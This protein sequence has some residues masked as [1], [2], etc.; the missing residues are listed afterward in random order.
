MAI[1]E[2]LNTPWNGHT[3]LEVEAF[4]KSYLEQL[5]SKIGYTYV[6][7]TN[8]DNYL[9]CFADE[10]SFKLW[11]SDPDANANLLIGGK[12]KLPSG[13]GASSAYSAKLEMIEPSNYQVA[14]NTGKVKVKVKYYIDDDS[15][16][17]AGALISILKSTDNGITFTTVG[18][19]SIGYNTEEFIDISSYLD[20]GTTYI[21]LN[22]KGLI[23]GATAAA[24]YSVLYAV[25]DQYCLASIN[26]TIY[27][28]DPFNTSF[29]VEGTSE[30]VLHY[31]V[32]NFVGSKNMGTS[33]NT[34]GEPIQI[35]AAAA[36]LTHGVHTIESWLTFGANNTETEH[37]FCNFIYAPTENSEYI[38]K[39]PLFVVTSEPTH[40]SNWNK[41]TFFDYGVLNPTS[42]E[43]EFKICLVYDNVVLDDY[44]T[45][46]KGD[47]GSFTKGKFFTDLR[48]D[49]SIVD[50]KEFSLQIKFFSGDEEIRNPITI[51]VDN[52]VDFGFPLNGPT[53]SID[54]NSSTISS[55]VGS[56]KVQYNIYELGNVSST[57]ASGWKT[58]IYNGE[59]ISAL[60]LYAGS[61]IEIPEE[62]FNLNTGW[63]SENGQDCSITFAF[64]I[65]TNNIVNED[66]ALI[67]IA[68]DYNDR[69]T[70]IRIYPTKACVLSRN[71]SDESI[72][73]VGFR[74]GVRTH[75]AVNIINNLRSTGL[76][77]M[78]IYVNGILSRE[79]RYESDDYFVPT[80]ETNGNVILGNTN[81][82]LT[83]F[84]MRIYKDMALDSN[85]ILQD[86]KASMTFLDEKIAF[87]TANSIY[88]GSKIDYTTCNKLG[89]NTLWYKIAPGNYYPQ[90]I[91]KDTKSGKA[92]GTELVVK[93][94]DPETRELDTKHS[95]V[96]K[97]MT[98]KGQGTTAK[99]YY[100]WNIQ[101]D[102]EDDEEIDEA[103]FQ[104][105]VTE[106]M[107]K[108]G[109]TYETMYEDKQTVFYEEDGTYFKKVS[110]FNSDDGISQVNASKYEIEDGRGGI[111]KLVG[112]ANYASSMQSHKL[113]SIW[114]FDEMW[115]KIV[116]SK[117]KFYYKGEESNGPIHAACYEKPFLVFYTEGIED[118]TEADAVFCG[119]QTWGSGKG[120]KQTFGYHKKSDCGYL[121]VSG[122]D[123]DKILTLFQMPWNE[124]VKFDKGGSKPGYCYQTDGGATKPLSFEVEIGE[125]NDD[126]M[127][128]NSSDVTLKNIFA[129]FVSWVNSLS[130]FLKKLP[131]GLTTNDLLTKPL[132]EL[133]AE[134]FVLDPSIQ[135][136]DSNY[137]VY[138]YDPKT[139]IFRPSLCVPDK[140]FSDEPDAIYYIKDKNL[141]DDS[142]CNALNAQIKDSRVKTFKVG[143]LLEQLNE[144]KFKVGSDK[145][146]NP[147]YE[148][149]V[150][151]WSEDLTDDEKT[152]LFIEARVQLF[153]DNAGKYI[154]I[155]DIVLHQD[156]IKLLAGTDNRAKNTYYWMNP[157]GCKDNL[158]RLKGDDLDTILKT[159]NS[160]KQSKPYYIEEH[161]KDEE[162][163]NYWNG[164]NNVFYTLVERA[165]EKEMR[166][167]M[168]KIFEAMASLESSVDNYFDKRYFFVQRYFPAVAYNETAR[169]LYETAELY[170]TTGYTNIAG[171]SGKIDV[172]VNPMEQSLGSQLECEKEWLSKRLVM[173]YG[174]AQYGNFRAGA[175]VQDA[176]KFRT[177]AKRGIAN[178]QGET[179]SSYH[180]E[181]TPYQ[182]LYP[183]ATL[184][185]TALYP[186][187]DTEGWAG[188]RRIAK[189]DKAIYEWTSDTDTLC[190]ILGMSYCA[191]L[192]DM[193]EQPVAGNDTSLSG[194][195]LTSFIGG[196][197]VLENTH[198]RPNSITFTDCQNLES[199]VLTNSDNLSGAF[200][201][202]QS[203]MVRLREL[204][205]RGTR[206]TSVSLTATD[207]L[208]TIELPSNLDTIIMSAQPNLTNFSIDSIEKLIRVELTDCNGLSN[209]FENFKNTF[210]VPKF[211]PTFENSGNFTLRL[212]NVNWSDVDIEDLINFGKFCKTTTLFKTTGKISNFIK[213]E[214]VITSCEEDQAWEL[215]DL[216]GIECFQP[217]AELHIY[218]NTEKIFLIGPSR[219]AEGS[220]HIKFEPLVLS[221]NRKSIE[222]YVMYTKSDT[223]SSGMINFA[224]INTVD[225]RLSAEIVGDYE[226]LEISA[227]E[228]GA[229][230]QK[231]TIYANHGSVTSSIGV[232]LTK[233][234][235]S[236]TFVITTEDGSTF[237]ADG[238]QAIVLSGLDKIHE[239]KVIE[240]EGDGKYIYSAI[241]TG[242]DI[243]N[244][245]E[246]SQSANTDPIIKCSIKD[247]P[248]RLSQGILKIT[249]T[250]S[251]ET[252]VSWTS[253][254]PIVVQNENVAISSFTNP[255]IFSALADV[256][257]QFLTY[258]AILKTECQNFTD[259]Q[260][261]GINFFKW[262]PKSFD[263]FQ[264]FT[265]L[266]TIAENKFQNCTE[267]RSTILP[268]NISDVGERAFFRCSSLTSITLPSNIKTIGNSAFE[269]CSSLSSVTWGANGAALTYLGNLAFKETAL[270]TLFIPSGS[271]LSIGYGIVAGCSKLESFTG[272]YISED[273]NILYK[274]DFIKGVTKN[275][276]DNEGKLVVDPAWISGDGGIDGYVF[277]NNNLLNVL[278]L[279][280]CPHN[281]Y[282]NTH[283]FDGSNISEIIL[284]ENI[285]IHLKDYS[286]ANT[287]K[288]KKLTDFKL[289]VHSDTKHAFYNSSIEE[290]EITKA[291]ASF[292]KIDESMFEKCKYLKTISYPDKIVSLGKN[293]FKGC[294]SLEEFTIK[295]K[296]SSIGED[297]FDGCI[298]LSSIKSYNPTAPTTVTY[299]FGQ[300]SSSSYAG[301]A[302]RNKT[303][304]EGNPYNKLF[305]PA[306][307][308]GYLSDDKEGLLGWGIL[309]NSTFGKFEINETL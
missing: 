274:D 105:G 227:L 188:T 167:T 88:D 146:N 2:N 193:S 229:E 216:F 295:E 41:V 9:C 159:D 272:S 30:K 168:F 84:G 28:T 297:C 27:N 223:T 268:A 240:P 250:K 96:F 228:N 12:Q 65:M 50:L 190:G 257:S 256:N 86:Y 184:G 51:T 212:N 221:A 195:R 133:K 258:S 17:E 200:T 170:R 33:Y 263:E 108:Y 149:F 299:S 288:M 64:D 93:I 58:V 130:P 166:E 124:D 214:I 117:R 59:S 172:A 300:I 55:K 226:V 78:R 241:I 87:N 68:G 230:D 54:T 186:K 19:A 301:F 265:G 179:K 38:D 73:D 251:I 67:S 196:N 242:K 79:Y 70:G 95:G 164:E 107:E 307:S 213:G 145:D 180:I 14:T 11:A 134:G 273:G 197:E 94:Y 245:L 115:Q 43:K 36:G 163:K 290:I 239:L 120:D 218:C 82:D 109:D 234:I 220:D 157:L 98:N 142:A 191:S 155:D 285:S 178:V 176:F 44:T 280:K 103:T 266:T 123:N 267:L 183:L 21:K 198:F 91:T 254:F 156:V 199:L 29:Y 131:E 141:S 237:V 122:A 75:I 224:D 60:Q 144:V 208:E 284:V 303:D 61:R 15:I 56:N 128:I 7:E 261:A 294:S 74:E 39:T 252:G 185:E 147:I 153:A 296:I 85:H 136:W 231:F 18:N 304:A 110:Y 6:E 66:E 236:G 281:M 206:Y 264:Y 81:A 162:N 271:N 25:V 22:A 132:A 292:P 255:E 111:S 1:I 46:I 152:K 99:S 106:E 161:D 207:R 129:P 205:L 235:Y 298:Y 174:Y 282:F 143:T 121:C 189:G 102:F 262:K 169:L 175:S 270:T 269:Q 160:G 97:G 306:I 305:I 194:K 57:T 238:A 202:K 3:G 279:S 287:S 201:D 125:K 260:F 45:V 10:A 92:K 20:R 253:N 309:T 246:L 26:P 173:L 291:N 293:A 243:T 101:S 249:C 244:Y 80:D 150:D 32:G 62:F 83:I 49:K 154:D 151:R 137:N 247:E 139:A 259:D 278:D 219:I 165:F 248:A 187:F 203:N 276:F 181:F 77:Y 138:Y 232:T 8:E 308:T 119:F 100:W 127:A 222:Y 233:R 53:F 135:Y 148:S 116:N 204:K 177:A 118:P 114:F 69:Y 34:Q 89:Y 182:Y 37:R 113:G 5:S 13:G 289:G 104:V 4:I 277:Y 112:K 76:N 126:D 171:M 23:S 63:T 225:S 158:I 275:A 71:K 286:L 40:C 302:N 140:L 192:G 35:N 217:N 72:A 209:D 215:Y 211:G 31:K 283:S 48:I 47:A 90:L 24:V 16:Q 210:L 42:D 52:S